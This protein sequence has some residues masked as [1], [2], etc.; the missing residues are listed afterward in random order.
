MLDKLQDALEFDNP[1]K[2]KQRS[3][4]VFGWQNLPD[5]IVLWWR[6]GDLLIIPRGFA[7]RF[8]KGLETGGHDVEWKDRRISKRHS[9]LDAA[10]SPVLRDYQ[11]K[12][13]DRIIAVQ[14]GIYRA[15][16]GAGKTV[17]ILEAIRRTQQRALVIVDKINIAE[18]WRERIAEHLGVESGLIGDGAWEDRQAISVAL[19]QTLWSRRL[20]LDNRDWWSNFGFVCLDEMHHVPAN[21]YS[22]VLQRFPARWRIGASATPDMHEEWMPLAHAVLGEIVH[23]TTYAELEDEGVTVKP[24]VVAVRS[25]FDYPFRRDARGRNNYTQMVGALAIDQA[26]N[27]RIAD[28]LER[29]KG[30]HVLVVSDRLEHLRQ[31]R[32]Y[33]WSRGW[34]P[35]D[36]HDFTGKQTRQQR[37]E[38]VSKITDSKQSLTFSTIAREALDVPPFDRIVLAWPVKNTGAVEQYIGRIRRTFPGKSDA[39]VYDVFDQRVGVLRNQFKKRRAFYARQDLELNFEGEQRESLALS[40]A[41]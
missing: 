22:S 4:R 18:Q 16:P 35:W 7:L 26:R 34:D 19:Q 2:I 21:T 32:A 30:H 40:E 24:R 41:R 38:I 11:S 17:A 28:V 25:D 14:Q 8:K 13:V 27:S 36:M 39:V 10:K 37:K 12:A 33:A 20:E 6:V 1:E 29:E 23:E 15:P 9:K 3:Q 5:K 31:L